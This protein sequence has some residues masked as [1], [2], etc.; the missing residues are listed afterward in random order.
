M[1][2]RVLLE[3][4]KIRAV[5]GESI[6]QQSSTIDTRHEDTVA[7]P[8]SFRYRHVN[9]TTMASIMRLRIHLFGSKSNTL[10]GNEAKITRLWSKMTYWSKW[11]QIS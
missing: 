3:N 10:L 2:Q 5:K 7:C 8:N 9:D 11:L 1:S 6:R 4:K